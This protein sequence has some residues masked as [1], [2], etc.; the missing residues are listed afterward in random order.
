[1]FNTIV[2]AGGAEAAGAA[3]HYGSDQTTT[4]A[5]TNTASNYKLMKNHVLN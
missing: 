4:P 1:M 5:S 3:L 2:G